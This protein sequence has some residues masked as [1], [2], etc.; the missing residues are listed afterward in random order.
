MA[1][2]SQ[3]LTPY[4]RFMEK[5]KV[6]P[7]TQCWEWQA[8]RNKKGY[9]QFIHEGAILAHR[10]S[11]EFHIGKIPE[12]LM[13]CHHCD[14]PPCVNPKHFFLGTN[15]ENINDAQRKGRIPTAKHPSSVSYKGGCRC[16]LCR[17]FINM[18][19][20]LSE[21]KRKGIFDGEKFNTIAKEIEYL[22]SLRE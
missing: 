22:K 8:F 4:Q 5:V 19:N 1:H 11:Y 14:N 13:V 12:G 7:T 15:K 16:E 6:N 9:G 3:N 20:T 10:I 21:L 17:R 18:T 2:K